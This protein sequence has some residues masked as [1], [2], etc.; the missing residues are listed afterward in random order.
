MDRA[1]HIRIVQLTCIVPD[2]HVAES[3]LGGRGVERHVV[4]EY[5]H[6]GGEECKSGR[7]GRGGREGGR[8][9]AC[10]TD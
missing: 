4:S 9:T 5:G 1:L 10:N 3:R 8:G 2:A 6:K 7:G